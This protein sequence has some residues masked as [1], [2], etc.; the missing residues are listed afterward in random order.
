MKKRYVKRT[1]VLVVLL[2]LLALLAWLAISLI[3]QRGKSDAGSFDFAIQDTTAIS[4]IEIRDAFGKTITLTKKNGIWTDEN[5]KCVEAQN[6][7]LILDVAK[8][9]EFKGYLGDSSKKKLVN[10]MSTQHIR[11]RFYVDGEWEKTWYIGPPSQDHY[12]QIMLLETEDNGKSKDPVMMRIR[13]FKGFISP[14]FFADRKKWM[15]TSLFSYTQD[16]IESVEVMN[17]ENAK[18]SFKIQRNGKRFSV[19]SLGKSLPFL[20]TANV[21]RYLQE[22]RNIHFNMA[23]MELNKRQCDSLLRSPFYCRLTVK[24]WGGK[25]INLRLYRIKSE[26]A[27][28]NEMGEMAYWD[29]N[30]LWAAL[31]SGELVKCQYF[32]F[33]PLLMG[34]IYF[35]GIVELK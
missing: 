3:R 9:I 12:G 29:M 27:Q 19:T 31:P 16:Q 2:L 35:P 13:G 18:L 33:N 30:M 24:P 21:Y 1:L 6:I 26:E 23:N 15:C 7:S 10:L 32:V 25:A 4:A 28:R 22:Y 14:R 34:Q 11:V 17:Q 20:D 8:N 5:G